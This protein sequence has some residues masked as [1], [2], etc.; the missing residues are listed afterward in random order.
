MNYSR[1]ILFLLTLSLFGFE[2][3]CAYNSYITD[4]IQYS[5]S[6][7]EIQKLEQDF[8]KAVAINDMNRLDQIA[9][10]DETFRMLSID[11]LVK[12]TDD[13]DLSEQVKI[14]IQNLI[15]QKYAAYFSGNRYYLHTEEKHD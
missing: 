4:H 5:R 11:F 1:Y 8:L 12:I 9:L 15:E 6:L 14:K 3:Q 2:L 7:P 13:A 10:T